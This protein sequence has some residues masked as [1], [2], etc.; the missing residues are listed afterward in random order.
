MYKYIL[1]ILFQFKQNS[2]SITNGKLNPFSKPRSKRCVCFSDINSTH[3][4]LLSLMS[5]ILLAVHV[6]YLKFLKSIVTIFSRKIQL[7]LQATNMQ[8]VLTSCLWI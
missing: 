1:F 8:P 7:F 3:Q 5:H 6:Q 4:S 2:N